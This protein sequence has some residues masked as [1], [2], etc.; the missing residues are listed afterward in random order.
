VLFVLFPDLTPGAWTPATYPARSIYQQV[1]REAEAAG[2]QVYDLT[3]AFSAQGGDWKRWWA[4]AYDSHPNEAAY[5]V[6]ARAITDEIEKRDLLRLP[7]RASP[8]STQTTPPPAR[9]P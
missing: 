2:L 5:E 3:E 7:A 4:T 8:V 9:S 6:V 1:A